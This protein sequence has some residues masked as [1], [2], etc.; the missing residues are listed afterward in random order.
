MSRPAVPRD[1]FLPVVLVLAAVAA[2][3]TVRDALLLLPAGQWM[4]IFRNAPPVE[5]AELLARYAEAGCKRVHLWPLGDEPRQVELA[6]D[7]TG[8]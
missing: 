4:A 2:V 5:P 8:K 6:A 7:L 3:M 1:P